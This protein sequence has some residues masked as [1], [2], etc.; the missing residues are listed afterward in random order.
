MR[1][2]LRAFDLAYR[3]G[4]EE[5]LVVLPGADAS[6]AERLA[7]RL[8]EIIAAVQLQRRPAAHDELR[9]ERLAA[10]R[11]SSTT[12]TCSER[13]TWRSSRPSAPDAIASAWPTRSLAAGDRPERV[14]RGAVEYRPVDQPPRKVS[15]FRSLEA[16]SRELLLA[17]TAEAWYHFGDAPDVADAARARGRF[18]RRR[19]PAAG[20][21]PHLRR[22]VLGGHAPRPQPERSAE[23]VAQP[24]VDLRMVQQRQVVGAADVHAV[25]RLERDASGRAPRPEA[26]ASSTSASPSS[27]AERMPRGCG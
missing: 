14:V 15:P 8:R 24:L 9:R 2:E 19:R 25:L 18:A 12:R 5:F 17:E 27:R 4:G 23:P 13:P 16:T 6:Q 1:K 11:G 7:E 3:L 26:L 20:R 21:R 22:A 10:W